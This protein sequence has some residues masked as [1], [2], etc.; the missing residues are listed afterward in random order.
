M[1]P[2]RK[3]PAEPTPASIRIDESRWVR[4]K[5]SGI[6]RPTANLGA[7]VKKGDKLGVIADAFGRNRSALKAS[8]D[9]VVIARANNP[10]V[11]RGDG[12][13]HLGKRPAAPE[14]AHPDEA[15]TPVVDER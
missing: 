12:V 4:A 14:P 6:F 8:F 7:R 10:L 3:A 11:H 5:R 13:V 15:P 1:L 2:P 9:G